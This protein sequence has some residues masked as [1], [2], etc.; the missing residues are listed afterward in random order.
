M[1]IKIPHI[2]KYSSKDLHAHH[3]AKNVHPL[4]IND[5]NKVMNLLTKKIIDDVVKKGVVY[6]LPYLGK[7]AVIAAEKMSSRKFIDW[8]QSFKN[9]QALIEKGILPLKGDNGGE[10]WMAFKDNGE[11]FPRFVLKKKTATIKRFKNSFGFKSG[12]YGR[13]LIASEMKAD[14]FCIN[15]YQFEGNGL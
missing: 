6:D 1:R 15:R 10:P 5:Y 2:K 14:E 3:K 12:K 7:F 11:T 9:K 8:E 4:N 13:Q